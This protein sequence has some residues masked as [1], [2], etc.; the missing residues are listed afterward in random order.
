MSRIR[1]IKPG[2]FIDD[3]LAELPVLTRLLFI[4]LWTLADCKGR[5]E[6]RQKKIRAQLH[7]YD[8]GDTDA[9]LQSLHDGRFITRY[10]VGGKRYLEIR[11]FTRHQRLTG[12]EAEEESHIPGPTDA[13]APSITLE[14]GVIAEMRTVPQGNNGETSGKDFSFTNAQEGKGKE[15]KGEEEERERPIQPESTAAPTLVPPPPPAKTFSNPKPKTPS[16]E[17]SP[18]LAELP[19]ALIADWNT[20]RPQSVVTLAPKRRRDIASALAFVTQNIGRP[21]W[22]QSAEDIR[23]W[24]ADLFG[25][26]AQ[27][28]GYLKTRDF[29]FFTSPDRIAKTVEG[30]YELRH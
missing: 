21:D 14:Q 17:H 5:L 10:E 11:T 27:H 23:P 6:D 29:D 1:T 4:G 24:F 20:I 8:D 25:Y 12:K 16:L 7:P 28:D 19:A 22:P 3:D 2:F 13:T 30:A 9:M 26:A 15:R 18:L